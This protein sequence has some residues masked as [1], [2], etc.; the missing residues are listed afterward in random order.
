MS[1]CAGTHVSKEEMTGANASIAPPRS[2]VITVTDGSPL[3]HRSRR[4]ASHVDD[5]KTAE[6]ELTLDLGQMLVARHLTVVEAGQPADLD[7]H[8]TIT[9]VRSGSAAARLLVG[10]GAG[11]A[12]LDTATTLSAPVALPPELLAFTTH[13]TTGAMPGAGLGVM[14]A[15]GAAGTAVHMIGP[16]LGVPGTL[17]QGLAQEAHQTTERIDDEMAKLFAKMGWPYPR[18]PKSILSALHQ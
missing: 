5:V 4:V 18:P 16:L 15:T 8:C 11:K 14:S 13:S 12:V 3:P 7:L 10:Y 2:I 17:K 9:S 6:R 1:G